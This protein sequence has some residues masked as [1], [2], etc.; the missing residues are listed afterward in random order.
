M[1]QTVSF[2]A[3]LVL[4]VAAGCL[5]LGADSSAESPSENI[6]AEYTIESGGVPEEI[7]SATAT[8]QVTFVESN[9]DFS[10]N[11][12][13]QETYL[14]PYK[15]TPTPISEPSG[16]CHDSQQVSIDL[17]ELNGT[18]TLADAAPERFDAGHGLIVTNLTATYRN[19][20]SVD[21]IKGVGSHRANI[22]QGHS[23]SQ[24]SVEIAIEGAE[25]S[26]YD[27]VLVSETDV[28]G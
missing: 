21:A 19:G 28:S 5:G 14:G 9:E 6:S 13:W 10:R 17:T 2:V 16:D 18:Q 26:G 1:R 8:M 23:N 4:V 12:C 11:S 22:V 15:P 25:A 3:L 27:Y 20:T 24:Y 7:E